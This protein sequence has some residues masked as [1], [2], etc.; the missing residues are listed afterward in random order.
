MAIQLSKDQQQYLGAGAIAF[1]LLTGAYVKFFWLPISQKEAELTDQ[2]KTIETK[3]AKAEAQASRL[4]RLQSELAVLN[5]QAI[6]AEKRLPK[7]KD[8]PDILVTLSHLGEKNRVAIMGISPGP[9]KSQQYFTELN[10]PMSVKG[11][12][13]DIG[14]F[15]A[16][17]ALETRIFNIKDVVYPAAGS[18]GEMT[19]TFTLLTYQYKG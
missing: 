3:I 12:Y 7:N 2:I 5:Q 4:A 14:R 1:L 17:I 11:S 15:F 6:E 10:Y 18:G 8:V 13:H 19:V 16:A 9:T